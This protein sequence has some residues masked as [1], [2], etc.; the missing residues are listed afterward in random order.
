MEDSESR[1]PGCGSVGAASIIAVDDDEVILGVLG[2]MLSGAKSFKAFATAEGFLAGAELGTCDL[3]LMDLNIA[4]ADGLALTR[5]VKA[6]APHCDVVVITGEATLDNALAAIRAGAYDF[7]TKP[8]SDEY[9]L[10]TV[11]RCLEKRRISSELSA[12]KAA[13]KELSAA[14]AQL[15]AVERMKEA[16]LSVIGHELRTPL[17]KILAG[18]EALEDAGDGEARLGLLGAVKRGA[19]EL[20]ETIENLILYAD[21]RKTPVPAACDVMDLGALAAEVCAG[22]SE[23]AA[24]AGVKITVRSPGEKALITGEMAL[25]R[26][27]VRQLVLNAIRFN[28]EGGSV[29]VRVSRTPEATSVMVSDTGPGIPAEL[30]SGLGN[31]FYQVADYL[32]RKSGGLGL[33]LAIVK[34]VAE[35]HKGRVVVRNAPGG[36]TAFTAAFGNGDPCSP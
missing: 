34:N 21:S 27:A 2:R 18:A 10:S 13:Q 25:V 3:L 33:G 19:S 15:R 17:A 12:V 9:L 8:F 7:V 35:A 6:L 23:K 4:G 14:Y 29:E 20:R 22:L 31:P 36:G 32:T 1:G 16:F 24:A 26:E 11:E 30:L 28:R 5:R